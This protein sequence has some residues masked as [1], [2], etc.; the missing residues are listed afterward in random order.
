MLSRI[1]SVLKYKVSLRRIAFAKY[2]VLAVCAIGTILPAS[3]RMASA[4]STQRMLPPVIIGDDGGGRIATRLE[5]IERYKEQG[6]EVR[7]TGNSCFSSCTLYLG[8][9]N[10]C[11]YPKTRFGFHGPNWY[12]LARME[13]EVFER[14]SRIV[15]EYYPGF[16]QDW[17]MNEA[18]Y[19]FW[20]FRVLRGAEL[21]RHGIKEC[22][23]DV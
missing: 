19:E 2:A 8:L 18:R 5:D 11:V 4:N 22:D 21:I 17:F 16:L 1:P 12:G 9:E 15:V 7:I 10:V 13:G 20:N 6:R 3:S 23:K 14:I